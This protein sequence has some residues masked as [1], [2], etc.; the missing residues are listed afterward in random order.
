L[1]H[2]QWKEY[3]AILLLAGVV[4]D[5]REALGQLAEIGEPRVPWVEPGIVRKNLRVRQSRVIDGDD[6]LTEVGKNSDTALTGNRG[7]I[8]CL[9]VRNRD[10]ENENERNQKKKSEEVCPI[11][12]GR[13][14]LSSSSS[15]LLCF[16]PQTKRGANSTHPYQRHREAPFERVRQA[17]P[18]RGAR[19]DGSV[20]LKLAV[21]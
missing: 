1:D 4:L 17:A 3:D 2:A 6:K 5:R 20:S 15:P 11:G 12:I 16:E 19:S 10:G 7:D 13:P 14:H 9:R 18:S 21:S 8:L